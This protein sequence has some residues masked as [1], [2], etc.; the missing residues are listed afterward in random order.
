MRGSEG[1]ERSVWRWP[2]AAAALVA[3][4]AHLPITAPHLREA[5]YIGWSFVGLEVVLT[6]VALGLLLSDRTP[7]WRAAGTVPALAMIAYAVTR[8]VSLPQIEDDVG[9][10]TPPLGLVAL[11][12]E[13]LLIAIT[14]GR[15]AARH[16][17]AWLTHRP[18]LWAGVVLAVGLVATSYATA[19][20]GTG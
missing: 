15:N 4:A 1:A 6:L 16:P 11:A 7:V 8:T 12:A 3:V 17:A 5:P 10:W 2:A 9:N 14:L 19:V 13:A 18:I 20:G